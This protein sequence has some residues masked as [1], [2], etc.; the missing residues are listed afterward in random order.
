M[1]NGL[2]K[3]GV[4]VPP[5]MLRKKIKNIFTQAVEIGANWAILVGED[6]LVQNKAT[7]KNLTTKEQAA[8]DFER[9]LKHIH[10]E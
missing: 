3:G 2:R 6:E 7:V 4:S 5:V 9:V 8:V 10:P 1:A